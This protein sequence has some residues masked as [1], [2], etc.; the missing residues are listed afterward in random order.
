MVDDSLSLAVL[1]TSA[2][3]SAG[4]TA[5][6]AGAEGS[7]AG[8]VEAASKAASAVASRR[9]RHTTAGVGPIVFICGGLRGGNLLGDMYV[10]EAGYQG[11]P[12][13][14]R[15]VTGCQSTQ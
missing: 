5:L 2:G 12:D 10:M 8:A 1:N 3:P 14:A 13:V 4:W 7:T 15:H 9:C 6:S 11:L